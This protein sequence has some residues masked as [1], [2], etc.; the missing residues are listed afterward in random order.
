MIYGVAA[1]PVGT[2]G[3]IG[4]YGTVATCTAQGLFN[5]LSQAV[6]L[7]YVALSVFS[8]I[9]VVQGKFDP[10]KYAWAEKYIHICV[11]LWAIVS[12]SI[13]FC[14]Q[15]FNPSEG[16]PGC[17][18]GS[19]PMGCGDDSG[20]PCQRGPQNISKVLAAFVFLPVL[21]LLVVPTITMVALALYLHWRNRCSEGN[22]ITAMAVTKQS[23]VY[24]G[25]LY[26]I[27]TPGLVMSSMG[28]LFGGGQN[29]ALSYYGNAITVSMGFWYALVYRY[30]SAPSVSGGNGII[31]AAR[32]RVS[33]LLDPRKT[34]RGSCSQAFSV[35]V[36]DPS[37]Q[38]SLPPVEEEGRRVNTSSA[39]SRMQDETP[40]ESSFSEA[41]TNDK[42][43][44]TSES[45]EKSEEFRKSFSFNIFDGTAPS[46]SQ[47]AEFIFDGD[48]SDEENDREETRYWAGCQDAV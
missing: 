37:G 36:G 35:G 41:P 18:I 16:W 32:R 33:K 27:Y 1:V 24:L 28:I 42:E 45:A 17:Y 46:Q 31:G 43:K 34:M 44:Q 7:Y 26:F 19:V 22:N 11:N 20:I 2:P 23:A 30:F 40:T 25:T 4:A 10:S 6:P 9:V 21:V 39:T 29:L 8:W 48:E 15:A 47:W 12:S 13:L 38:L 14:L 5:Q 3:V